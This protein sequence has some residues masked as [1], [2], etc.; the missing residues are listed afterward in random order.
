M[1]FLT[2]L[3]DWE[4]RLNAWVAEAADTPFA[5]GTH[6]CALFACRAVEA[7]T[8][9][10]PFP[11]FIGKYDDRE[12]AARALRLI[13]EG[14]LDRTFGSRF[15]ECEPAFAQRGDI[16]MAEGAL[17]VCM[18]RNGLFLTPEMGL[19]SLPRAAFVKAWRI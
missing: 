17:G 4:P 8:G 15:A 18:G 14:T 12:G 5:W 1:E 7:M 6:D 9:T 3:D 19:A 2:R 10:H 11:Q 16:V 13:G